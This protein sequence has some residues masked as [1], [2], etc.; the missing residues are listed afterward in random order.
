MKKGLPLLAGLTALALTAIAA[1]APVVAVA[2]TIP[3]VANEHEAH[4]DYML[5][6][7][8][9]HR[10]DGVGDTQSNPPLKDMVARFLAVPGG[11]AFLGRVPGV[12]MVDLDDRRTA[13]VLNWALFRFDRAH[14]PADFK[15]YTAEELHTLRADPIRLDRLA[16]RGHLVAQMEGLKGQ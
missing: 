12:S 16:I 9:C 8:G 2:D 1:P 14:V 4:I 7:Q 15:P 11:R 10:P 3:G 5:K 13:Q 6:C